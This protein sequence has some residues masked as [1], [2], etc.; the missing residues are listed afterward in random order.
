MPNGTPKITP[1][2]LPEIEARANAATE[3]PWSMYW[4]R[5]GVGSLVAGEVKHTNNGLRV[6]D[7]LAEFDAESLDGDTAKAE[8]DGEFVAHAR[9]DIPALCEALREAWAENRAIHNY[10]EN[11]LKESPEESPKEQP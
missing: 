11:M 1:D 5:E 7:W 9:T 3:G 6:A 4:E 2:N 8:N 10:Y